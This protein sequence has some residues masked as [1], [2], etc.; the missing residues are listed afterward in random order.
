M[1][2]RALNLELTGIWS[3]NIKNKA[4]IDL[5]SIYSDKLENKKNAIDI[6]KGVKEDNTFIFSSQD[7]YGYA[8]QEIRRLKEELFFEG[9]L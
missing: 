2:N 1:V 4:L 3:L 8:Q 5:A 9:G 6:L 7:Y